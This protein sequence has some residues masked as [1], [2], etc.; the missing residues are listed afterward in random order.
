MRIVDASGEVPTSHEVEAGDI[1]R[2]CQVK[3]GPI[4]DWIK[5]AVNRAG[6][7][8]PGGLLAQLDRP[9]DAQLI[10]KVEAYLADHDT[11]GLNST[12]WPWPT[13][14]ASAW[15]ASGGARTP[16]P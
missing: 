15:S 7:R 12:S 1:W 6:D 11:D 9:H 8:C 2:A 13:R 16:S 10:A 14:A 5:L 3:D 4:R